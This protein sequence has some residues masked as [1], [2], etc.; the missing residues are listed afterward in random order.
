MGCEPSGSKIGILVVCAVAQELAALSAREGVDVVAVGVGPVEAA[1][2]TARALAARPYDAVVNAGIAGGFRDRCTVGDVVVC[3]RED[4]A[5]LGL[6]DGTG[7]PLPGGL[8]LVRSVEADE[9]LLRPFINGLIPVIVGRGVTSAIVTSTT[10][11]AL[12]LAHRFRAD[13]ESMEGFS[14]LR[15]A[16]L[17]GVPAIEIRGVSNLV[18]ERESNGW[19]FRAGAAAAVATADA[20]LDVLLSV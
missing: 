17:A 8:Q 4:Y 7:F 14:V 16:Q 15:A 11:R 13:V 2:G 10:A 20:L 3:S 18:G 19:D 1:A 12:V 9:T 5:E 6:E